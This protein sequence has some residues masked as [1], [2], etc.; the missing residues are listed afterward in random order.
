MLHHTRKVLLHVKEKGYDSTL[1]RKKQSV[2]RPE[3]AP[4]EQHVLP[5]LPRMASTSENNAATKSKASKDEELGFQEFPMENLEYPSVVKLYHSNN[6]TLALAPFI[7]HH[8]NSNDIT[9]SCSMLQQ[10]QEEVNRQPTLQQEVTTTTITTAARTTTTPGAVRINPSFSNHSAGENEESGTIASVG[11]IEINREYRDPAVTVCGAV[12]LEAS[13]PL[14]VTA[15]KSGSSLHPPQHWTFAEKVWIFC[16]CL[17]AISILIAVAGIAVVLS[18]R[19]NTEKE[20][21]PKAAFLS[22][23]SPSLTPSTKPLIAYPTVSPPPSMSPTGSAVPS[24]EVYHNGP[25]NSFSLFFNIDYRMDD[26]HGDD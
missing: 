7:D 23:L 13:P 16:L 11:S 22:S 25:K 17:L 19:T 20:I 21:P 24:Y 2:A 4:E 6:K 1:F 10:Q 26:A 14:V 18:R 15:E 5:T 8:A 9:L 3:E 12:V